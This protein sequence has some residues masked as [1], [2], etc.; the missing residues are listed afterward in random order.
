MAPVGLPPGLR[1]TTEMLWQGTLILAIGDV[2]VLGVLLR[3]A[4][5]GDF[6]RAAPL[7][8]AG[9]ALL[10][11]AVWIAAVS[12][13]WEGVYAWVFPAWSRWLLPPAM[14]LLTA[15]AATLSVSVLRGVRWGG[16][17][18]FALCGGV[19]GVLTHTWAVHRGIV[20]EPPALRGA[21]AA[22]A[23]TI[24]FFEFTFYWGVVMLAVMAVQRRARRRTARRAA[25]MA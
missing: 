5:R 20:R 23:V 17:G 16:P 21:S 1:I 15:L 18:A 3:Y 25:H 13:A 9:T 19:W 22:A 24:A 2:V 11:L 12:L 6:L 7:L 10:W 8:P 4:Q 14:A